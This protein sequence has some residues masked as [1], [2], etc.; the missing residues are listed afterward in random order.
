MQ[1]DK[2]PRPTP[3]PD[4]QER[5]KPMREKA[6]LK[7]PIGTKFRKPFWEGLADESS[8]KAKSA[9]STKDTLEWS[10]KDDGSKKPISLHVSPTQRLPMPDPEERLVD[11]LARNRKI[12]AGVPA[13]VSMMRDEVRQ[14]PS[15][16][17]YCTAT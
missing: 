3:K 15:L 8:F 7:H 6:L 1:G 12:A 14:R 17:D 11:K 5:I 9:T 13:M 10:T 16:G 2:T 4:K